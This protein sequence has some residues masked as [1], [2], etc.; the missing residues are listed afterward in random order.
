MARPQPGGAPAPAN[1]RLAP[2]QR[3]EREQD[4][5]PLHDCPPDVLPLAQA[6]QPKRPQGLED[7]S[8]RPKQ[9]KQATWTKDEVLAV[10]AYENVLQR[11]GIELSASRMGRIL[12][13]LKRTRQL[14]SRCTAS[15]P[16]AAPGNA[17]TPLANRKVTR[18]GFPA[19]SSR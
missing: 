8:S 15:P 10:K 12:G 6:L 17:S 13:Y 5:P 18:P 2:G 4:L 19:T 9:C 16:T 7:R 14:L 11:Q 3:C 1:D